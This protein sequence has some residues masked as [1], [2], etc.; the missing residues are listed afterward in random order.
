MLVALRQL[1]FAE[2][3]AEQGGGGQTAEH[4]TGGKGEHAASLLPEIIRGGGQAG[5]RV[6]VD[7]EKIRRVLDEG[8]VKRFD[9]FDVAI[10]DKMVPQGPQ[11]QGRLVL[12]DRQ[13]RFAAHG[14]GMPRRGQGTVRIEFVEKIP[15]VLND[16]GGEPVKL[17]GRRRV[18]GHI[19]GVGHQG[20][21]PRPD[22]GIGIAVE[23]D[24][25]RVIGGNDAALPVDLGI[26]HQQAAA[27]ESRHLFREEIENRRL[28]VDP[29]VPVIDGAV[30]QGRQ[31]FMLDQPVEPLH[32]VPFFPGRQPVVCLPA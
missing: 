14:P 8:P 17:L 3:R 24:H 25:V 26:E 12:L 29:Q 22:I 19:Q 18:A 15:F 10:D 20:P 28:L 27:V 4:R 32:I 7:A 1:R 31:G 16:P 5:F 30:K 9:E 23:L 21:V 6:N 11:H 13:L 2:H